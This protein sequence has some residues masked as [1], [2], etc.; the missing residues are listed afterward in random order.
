VEALAWLGEVLR[1]A[2]QV[3]LA[4]FVAEGDDAEIDTP[5]S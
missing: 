1:P 4:E 3:S 5:R 2:E